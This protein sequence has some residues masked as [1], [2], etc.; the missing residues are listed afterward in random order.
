M[1]N[2]QNYTLFKCKKRKIG[3]LNK[4]AEKIWGQRRVLHCVIQ[5]KTMCKKTADSEKPVGAPVDLN[6]TLLADSYLSC[7]SVTRVN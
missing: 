6:I 7:E 3:F 1:E 4:S 2:R 5:Y